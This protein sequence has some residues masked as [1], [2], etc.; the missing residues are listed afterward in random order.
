[1][2][3]SFSQLLVI[4]VLL[5]A[6][7]IA[8]GFLSNRSGSIED[9]SAQARMRR[10]KDVTNGSAEDDEDQFF[11]DRQFG[12]WPILVGLIIVAALGMT[13]WLFVS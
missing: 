12:G 3:I 8:R 1:M 11:S 7:F 6:V 4:F 5:A 2:G 10:E 9:L 13:T